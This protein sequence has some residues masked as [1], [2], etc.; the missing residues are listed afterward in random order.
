MKKMKKRLCALLA[1]LL[2]LT[3]ITPAAMAEDNSAVL[4]EDVVQEIAGLFINDMVN[5]GLETTWTTTTEV[6]SSTPLYD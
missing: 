4:S 6:V 5:S 1:T 2:L 3:G